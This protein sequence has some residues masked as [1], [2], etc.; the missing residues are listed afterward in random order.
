MD[1]DNKTIEYV[2]D[3]LRSE[4]D[5]HFLRFEFLQRTNIVSLERKLAKMKTDFYHYKMPSN[6]ELDKLQ[7]TL[8]Q[9][10]TCLDCG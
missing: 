8:Q 7:I 2:L 6:D 10:G 4:E 1:P 5:F 9:Y 3:S